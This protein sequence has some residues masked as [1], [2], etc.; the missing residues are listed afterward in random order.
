MTRPK[1]PQSL[2]ASLQLSVRT[3]H[4]LSCICPR[5]IRSSNTL[6]QTVPLHVR[7]H[8]RHEF[9]VVP[10]P[11]GGLYVRVGKLSVVIPARC[12]CQSSDEAMS[13]G[14]EVYPF[15]ARHDNENVVVRERPGGATASPALPYL[16]GLSSHVPNV[17][18]LRCRAILTSR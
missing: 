2:I 6:W 9:A 4:K 11:I 3:Y 12:R 1:A 7:R 5:P 10:A 14:A 16:A 17:T 18:S 13:K 15:E 8:L